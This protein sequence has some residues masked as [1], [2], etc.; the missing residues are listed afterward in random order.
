MEH[1]SEPRHALLFEVFKC[2]MFRDE[3]GKR[4]NNRAVSDLLVELRILVVPFIAINFE[5]GL[6]K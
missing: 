5:K 3:T 4:V 6:H 1:F 2:D